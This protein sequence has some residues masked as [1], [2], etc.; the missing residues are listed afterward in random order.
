MAASKACESCRYWREGQCQRYP[1]AV[2][3]PPE[4][5]CGEW[6]QKLARQPARAGKTMSPEVRAQIRKFV[7]A[8]GSRRAAARR[9]DVSHQAISQMLNG[10]THKRDAT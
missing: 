4:Y 10:L 7:R 8:G 6:R 9:W 2:A 1:S 5:W 3:T